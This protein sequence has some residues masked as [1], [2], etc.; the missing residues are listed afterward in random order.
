M[1][2]SLFLI[3]EKYHQHQLMTLIISVNESY[4]QHQLMALIMTV[5]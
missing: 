5:N 1:S 2:L 3:D 4:H